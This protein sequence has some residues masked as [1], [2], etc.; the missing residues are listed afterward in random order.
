M[1][2]R[3]NEGLARPWPPAQ[4]APP[5]PHSEA[6]STETRKGGPGFLAAASRVGCPWAFLGPWPLQKYMGAGTVLGHRFCGS[7]EVVSRP[8]V[9]GEKLVPGGHSHQL[10][11]GGLPTST[12]E[13]RPEGKALAHPKGTLGWGFLL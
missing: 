12:S 8:S 7:P 6:L 1:P 3:C 13:Q 4:P 5:P 10:P 11:H 2:A 9:R